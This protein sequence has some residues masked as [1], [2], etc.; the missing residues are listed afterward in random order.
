M[1]S[2]TYVQFS[3][4]I[5]QCT[6]DD[7]PRTIKYVRIFLRN[8]TFIATQMSVKFTLN[9]KGIYNSKCVRTFTFSLSLRSSENHTEVYFP[10]NNNNQVV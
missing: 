4:I 10:L 8:A 2:V 7:I 9:L 3:N 1:H 6:I 5:R